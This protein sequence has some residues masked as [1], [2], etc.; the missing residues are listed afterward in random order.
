MKGGLSVAYRNGTYVAFHANGRT[1]P[2]ES[3]MKYYNLLKAWHVRPS[4]D[5]EFVNSHEKTA[6]VRDSS[7]RETLRRALI[8]RLNNS[9]NM[10]L[11]IGETTREDTDWVP[12]EI[13]YAVDDCQIP[14]IVAYTDYTLVRAPADLSHL[15][16]TSL[17]ERIRRGSAHAIHIPFKCEPLTHA[18]NNFNYQNHPLGGALGIYSDQAYQNWGLL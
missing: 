9:K 5:F 16:P 3:D 14:L 15:W 1:Q 7:S 6:A 18:V 11:I 4:S 12:F 17:S 13:A 8:S 10:V 2:T